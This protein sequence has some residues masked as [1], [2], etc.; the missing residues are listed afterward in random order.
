LWVSTV[1]TAVQCSAVQ[2]CFVRTHVL[3]RHSS[4]IKVTVEF[5]RE[6]KYSTVQVLDSCKMLVVRREKDGGRPIF[7]RRM[8]K[9]IWNTEWLAHGGSCYLSDS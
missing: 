8:Q 6:A 3:L 4:S 5:M 2:S 9:P 7:G 1:A